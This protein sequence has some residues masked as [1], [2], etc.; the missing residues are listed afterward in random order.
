[1]SRHSEGLEQVYAARDVDAL[2]SAYAA[3]ANVY[4]S[5]TAAAGYCLPFMIT[6]WVARHVRPGDGP[7]LDAG[8]GSGLSGPYLKAL[9]YADLVGL[10]MSDEMLE[11]AR[12][13]NAY[14]ELATARLGDT[15]PWSDGHFAAFLCTG[16]FTEGHAPASS[17]LELARITRPGGHGIFTVRDSVLETGGFRAVFATLVDSGKWRSVEESG[18]FRA[19]AITEPD[20]LVKAFVFQAL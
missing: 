3:W 15:L 16:V 5:E 8:C 14:R 9:G 11:L 7:L 20:V 12:A 4:D 13:R 6:S 17:L 19:F 2:A 1:M 18:W 10:D